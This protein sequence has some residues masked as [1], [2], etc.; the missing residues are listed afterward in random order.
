MRFQQRYYYNNQYKQRQWQRPLVDRST[1]RPF[2]SITLMRCRWV[3]EICISNKL[4]IDPW[5][6]SSAH[7]GSTH[8]GTSR[9]TSWCSRSWATMTTWAV[10]RHDVGI[11]EFLHVRRL[12]LR[13]CAAQTSSVSELDDK[14]HNKNKTSLLLLTNWLHALLL[15]SGRSLDSNPLLY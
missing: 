10:H 11:P 7:T 3:P 8:A 1:R 6:V 4:G 15:L 14:H 2:L 9:T 13:R 12:C 5:L